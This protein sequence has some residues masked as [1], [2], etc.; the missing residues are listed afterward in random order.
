MQLPS[1]RT[2]SA[3][4]NAA[5]AVA[6]ALTMTVFGGVA[7][8]QTNDTSA[9]SSIDKDRRTWSLQVYSAA[10]D[11]DITVQVQRPVDESEPAPNLYLLSGLDAGEG[12]ASWQQQTDAL[13]F[14]SDKQVNVVLPI[15]GRGSYYADWRQEDPKLGVNKWQTFLTKELPPILDSALGSTGLNSLAGL[16]T[17]G[18]SVLQMAESAPG[19]F[20]T[21][22]AYSGCAQIADPIGRQFLKLPVET[23]AGGNTVNMYGPDDDP[24]WAENDPVINAEKLRGTNLYISSGSGIPQPEDVQYY[25]EGNGPQGVVNLGLGM[26]IEGAT[27]Y[28][29]HNLMNKLNELEIPATYQFPPVGT[30]YWPYWEDALHDSW[31]LLARGMGI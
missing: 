18:T 6:A 21:V 19:L 7:T 2:R 28:C 25:T 20:K 23:W 16:S 14:L 29:S 8:A 12:S 17:S 27:N 13:G 30:H 5:M 31:P 11:K 3:L 26:V 1:L 10:M 9:V 22:A 4:R 15:G 24:A